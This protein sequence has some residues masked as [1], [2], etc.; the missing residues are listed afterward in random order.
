ML[1]IVIVLTTASALESAV[2]KRIAV[3]GQASCIRTQLAMYTSMRTVY[4]AGLADIL[5]PTPKSGI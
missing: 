5:V 2:L 1:R 4:L 3:R